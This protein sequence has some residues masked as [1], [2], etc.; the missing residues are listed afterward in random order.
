MVS[1]LTYSTPTSLTLLERAETKDPQ[2]WKQLHSTYW[3]L[4]WGWVHRLEHPDPDA[5]AQDVFLAVFRNI[6][7]F[8]RTQQGS[9][10]AWLRTITMNKVREMNRKKIGDQGV[11]GTTNRLK[12][13]EEPI[14]VDFTNEEKT[15]V[16]YAALRA[17]QGQFSEQTLEAFR[18]MIWEG[19]S[20]EEV[21][22]TLGMSPSA[23]R[24]A[25]AR[26]IKALRQEMTAL[27][28]WDELVA[29]SQQ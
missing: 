7:G 24:Q 2:A 6:G 27:K 28:N 17:I 18:L 5:V 23:V 8:R 21:A 29:I 1:P 9:F 20:S 4:V 25:K 15:Q 22:G 12:I 13:E 19:M 11:G 10:R 16:L 3:P 26:V 14:P